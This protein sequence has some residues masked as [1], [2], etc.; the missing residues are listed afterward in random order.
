MEVENVHNV[1]IFTKHLFAVNKP[2]AVDKRN[3][4][5]EISS[6]VTD[7]KVDYAI[8]SKKFVPQ[9]VSN[10]AKFS[11]KKQTPSPK[12]DSPPLSPEMQSSIAKSPRSYLGTQVAFSIEKDLD[13]VVTTIKNSE[14]KIVRQ[15]PPE[16]I[17][18]RLKMLKSYYEQ[19]ANAKGKR[20]DEII[21]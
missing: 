21:K 5:N 6:N 3:S 4:K 12:N 8:L 10:S 17:V 13:I 16:E 1:D 11:S 2:G 18:S 19:V 14:N 15:I 7:K 20:L 9:N